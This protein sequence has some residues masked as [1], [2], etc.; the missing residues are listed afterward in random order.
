MEAPENIR[1]LFDQSRDEERAFHVRKTLGLI[2]LWRFSRQRRKADKLFKT[3][4]RYLN[5]SG[6]WR[7]LLASYELRQLW[8]KSLADIF[9]PG[10]LADLIAGTAT[11]K[12]LGL[13]EELMRSN[14]MMAKQVQAAAKK[15]NVDW[16]ENSSD[17]VIQI[18]TDLS[19]YRLHLKYYRFAH[20]IFNRI[21]ILTSEKDI[22]LSRQGNQLY[23]LL[24][25]A[26][27]E[28]VKS[29]I[30]HHTI[31]KADVRGST[32]VTS[33]LVNQKLNPAS[34][35]SQ[36]FFDPINV[37][38]QTYGAGKVFIEGDAVILSLME[39]DDTPQHWY[40][41][42]R[43]CGLA[44]EIIQ[45]V[46]SSNTFSERTGLPNL[47]I[48]IGIC[49]S[50][51]APLFLL[52]EG[53]QI[54]ISTAIGDADRMSS[55]SWKMR[56]KY[57]ASLFNVEVC[58]LAEGEGEKG[59][60]HVRYNVNGISLDEEAM[61]KL[62]S[63]IMLQKLTM[64]IAGE[65]AV[66]HAGRFPDVHGKNRDLVIRQAKMGIWKNEQ[67]VHNRKSGGY[68]YEVVTNAKVLARIGEMMS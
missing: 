8:R 41:I 34:Y 55:C 66:F 21:S 4:T 25:A 6:K 62:K 14:K 39:Y 58:R 47:E 42:S 53:K 16:K 57:R 43:A 54:M 36:R 32:T 50:D 51:E 61:K 46:A 7:T 30:V 68:F 22:A 15:V 9:E 13:M 52:E 33:E 63:E 29:K 31:V 26:E 23:S 11:K 44:K 45:V 65:D 59:Q 20:R 28:E 37:L 1:I 35:F 56:E 17:K 24:G 12:T 5:T 27:V 64:N 49:Y 40:S 60:H 48:G 2:A 67:V 19:R 38:L 10:Q 3:V 18:L